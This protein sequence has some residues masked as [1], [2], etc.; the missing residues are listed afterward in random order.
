MSYLQ[1]HLL[2]IHHSQNLVDDDRIG[3]GDEGGV[4][5]AG[6]GYRSR[7]YPFYRPSLLFKQPFPYRNHPYS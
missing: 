3:N 2:P 6:V 7:L 5:V 1:K 4:E